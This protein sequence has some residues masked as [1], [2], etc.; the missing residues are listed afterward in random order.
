MRQLLRGARYDLADR[1]RIDT[2]NNNP[3]LIRSPGPH[4]LGH[5]IGAVSGLI[6]GSPYTFFLFFADGSAVEVSAD[7]RGGDPRKLRNF[8]YSHFLLLFH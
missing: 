4:G 2:G 6:D 1:I 8:F 3:D 7:C 5:G